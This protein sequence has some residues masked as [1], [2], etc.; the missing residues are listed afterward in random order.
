MDAPAYAQVSPTP[1][2]PARNRWGRWLLAVTVVWA[3]L[4]AVLTWISVRD[5][6]PT[7]REQRDL[8]E[9]VPVV[10]RATGEL[11]AAASG[12]ESVVEL[13]PTEF[14]RGCRVTPFLDGAI[15]TRQVTV[16]F[17]TGTGTGTGSGSGSGTENGEAVLRRIAERLPADYRAGARRTDEG[18]RLRA[19]AGDFVAIYGEL[20]QPGLAELY[21]E[22]GCRPAPDGFGGVDPDPDG[23]GGGIRFEL[24]QVLSALGQPVPDVPEWTTVPC[25]GRGLAGTASA[26]T[27]GAL[28]APPAAL[29][30]PAAASPAVVVDT[31]ERYAYRN[32][33]LGVTVTV[34]DERTRVSVS[35]DCDR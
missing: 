12:P 35:L 18:F 33:P 29:L 26:D 24:T 10:D 30:R 7:V 11:V 9:A 23:P 34:T 20:P 3:V 15:L 8:A 2:P 6:P 31:P 28:P 13:G 16:H 22:T 21:V 5:D 4:L 25:P 19:D 14:E 1:E 27:P 17:G 32:G